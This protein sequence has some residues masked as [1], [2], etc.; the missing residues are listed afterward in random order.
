MTT[1]TQTSDTRF[2]HKSNYIEHILNNVCVARIS[3]VTTTDYQLILNT[4]AFLYALLF[5][6]TLQVKYY[7]D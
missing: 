3:I 5:K 6:S 4:Q 2:Y 7:N 1:A